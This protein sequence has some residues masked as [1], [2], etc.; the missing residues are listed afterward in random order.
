MNFY[1][2]VNVSSFRS[3]WGHLGVSRVS[4]RG[5]LA[6]QFSRYDTWDTSGVGTLGQRFGFD[7]QGVFFFEIVAIESLS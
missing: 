3:L 7:V 5:R 1:D 2:L 4:F 6:Q